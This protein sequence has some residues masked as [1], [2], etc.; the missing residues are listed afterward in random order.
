MT[1]SKKV[2]R[3]PKAGAQKSLAKPVRQA[4]K[5]GRVAAAGGQRGAE[6][7][8][9]KLQLLEAALR[10]SGGATIPALAKALDWQ[11]HSVRGAISGTLKKK[12]GLTITSTAV[13][14][15]ERTY[16]ITG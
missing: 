16:R 10:A 12:H 14:G 2:Q 3:A 8:Q 6:G 5:T 11:A 13:A 9:S 4:T 7:R 1:T 15:G